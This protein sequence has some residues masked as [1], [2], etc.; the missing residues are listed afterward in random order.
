[1]SQT[2]EAP[3]EVLSIAKGAGERQQ[4]NQT[5]LDDACCTPAK[6]HGQQSCAPFPPPGEA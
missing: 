3:G 6:R 4:V 5:T 1:M 2:K